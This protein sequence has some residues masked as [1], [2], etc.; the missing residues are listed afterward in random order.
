MKTEL[1][2]RIL[3][4]NGCYAVGAYKHELVKR[5]NKKTNETKTVN[6][7]KRFYE[8][9]YNA[10]AK[11]PITEY[12]QA[13]IETMV[14]PTVYKALKIVLA[15]AWTPKIEKLLNECVAYMRKMDMVVDAY[16]EWARTE[17]EQDE[18][19]TQYTKTHRFKLR[20]IET[21]DKNG[22]RKVYRFRQEC[23][24]YET[25]HYTNYGRLMNELNIADGLDVE[26]LFQECRLSLCEL[27]YMGVVSNPAELKE[28]RVYAFKAVHNAITKERRTESKHVSLTKSENEEGNEA[29]T[30]IETNDNHANVNI[31]SLFSGI[32]K[33]LRAKLKEHMNNKQINNICLTL[34][35]VY[36][37]GCTQQEV[38]ER[39]DTTQQQVSRYCK[40]IS[41]YLYSAEMITAIH[42]CMSA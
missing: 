23:I 37:N 2:I 15:K 41:K 14:A 18:G 1:K 13:V 40:Y 4:N 30:D 27:V 42:D 9:P 3:R 34:H 32:E 36:R 33:V 21:K 26:D 22:K 11:S 24:P 8:A 25:L 10:F 35:W 19:K 17:A 20:K 29:E 16:D 6:H 12:A 39:L 5:L 31:E 38:A 7:T 28:S